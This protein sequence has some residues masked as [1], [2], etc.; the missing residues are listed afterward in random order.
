V[1]RRP[2]LETLTRGTVPHPS[3]T[4]PRNHVLPSGRAAAL[5][6]FD[7]GSTLSFEDTSEIEERAAREAVRTSARV[8]RSPVKLH[9]LANWRLIAC[10]FL[11]FAAGYYLS[12]LFRTINTLISGRLTT[13]LGINAADL[14]LLASVYFLAFGAAQIPIG[15]LLD[16]FGPRRVQSA[17]LVV[18]AAGALLFGISTGF[19]ALLIA[20]TMIGFGVAAA[21]MAGLKAVVIWFPRDQVALVNGYMIMFGALG[22]VSAT[23]P[24]EWLMNRIG[25]RGLFEL[26]AV[27]TLATAL[28]IYFA[29]PEPAETQTADARSSTL[30]TVYLNAQFW[31]VAPLSAVCV[32]SAWALQGLWAAPWLTDVEGLD[33]HSLITRLFIMAI[34]ICVGAL[35]LGVIANRLRRRGIRT[36]I[37]LVALA[38]VFVMAELAVILRLPLPQLLPWCVVSMFGAATVL[39]YA[40]MA[41]SFP[42]RFAARANG[43][44][45]LL[46]FGW[47]FAAQY[48]IGLILEQWPRQGGHYPVI[49]YQTAFG[50]DV[51]VQVLALAWFIAPLL[52]AWVRALTR[53]LTRALALRAI[54]A[55]SS[56]LGNEGD[57]VETMTPSAE[58]IAFDATEDVNW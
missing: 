11:P 57:V 52:Y 34:S 19:Y 22:G 12:Y 33:R 58:M 51:A 29:V 30:K 41:E 14:G 28:M 21:L 31:R 55:I 1:D 37:V 45:N 43:G 50:L 3:T 44:L 16:R 48:G 8:Q 17:L 54:E 49:A 5:F 39:S 27:I 10:V 47:A 20:R 26:L 9:G 7:S 53:A 4:R 36:E 42:A 25:W 35:L 6:A 32:G 23:V 13:D 18:A 38:V 24:A 40:I 46:H 56:R 15:S 2:K